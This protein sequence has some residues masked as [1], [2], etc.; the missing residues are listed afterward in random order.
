MCCGDDLHHDNRL[1]ALIARVLVWWAA[2][3]KLCMSGCSGPP[4][5]TSQ[6]Y[7]GGSAQRVR[8]RSEPS[9][10]RTSA[11]TELLM[12]YGKRHRSGVSI[13][14]IP[15]KRVRASECKLAD[16]VTQAEGLRC[17]D[18]CMFRLDCALTLSLMDTCALA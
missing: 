4:I 9:P 12:G 13:Q 18:D 15:R 10:A 8:L 6:S 14:Y 7:P 2:R 5:T 16:D 1:P 3:T 11:D 17:I